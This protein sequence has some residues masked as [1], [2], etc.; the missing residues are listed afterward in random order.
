MSS[1][2]NGKSKSNQVE[3]E[4]SSSSENKEYPL[5]RAVASNNL[6]ETPWKRQTPKTEKEED[7][8]KALNHLKFQK[9]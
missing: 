6:S 7:V 1:T 8:S 9:K 5:R 3:N 4:S 2:N